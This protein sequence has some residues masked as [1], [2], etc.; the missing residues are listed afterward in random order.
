[1][2]QRAHRDVRPLL[3]GRAQQI[4]HVD[5]ADDIADVLAV[6]GQAA[7]TALCDHFD[8]FAYR[9]VDPGRDQLRAR[10]HHL[11]CGLIRELEHAVK[12][13][14]FLLF[15]DPGFLARRHQH[16]ELLFGMHERMPAWVV[17]PKH[18]HNRATH[19]VHQRDKGPERLHEQLGRPG[20]DER[21]ALG[22]LERDGLRREL[23][24]HNV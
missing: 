5:K 23:T 6:D 10:H 24:Q 22:V 14:L 20:H 16:L 11:A 19:P 15:E 7:I 13:L 4:A 17:E 18:A 3:G 1:M 9:R 12:H 8:G 21:G 2:H